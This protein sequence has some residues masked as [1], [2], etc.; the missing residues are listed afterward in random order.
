VAAGAES[1]TVDIAFPGSRVAVFVDGCFWHC[2]PSHGN[3]PQTNGWYWS[4]KLR[5]NVERDR[6]IDVM[7]KAAGWTSVRIW[8]HVAVDEAVELVALALATSASRSPG[9]VR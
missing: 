8:E 5:R 1:T 9:K 7:L 2:C 4:P 3:E 6:T